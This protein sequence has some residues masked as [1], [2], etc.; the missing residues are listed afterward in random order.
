M[1]KTIRNEYGEEDHPKLTKAIDKAQQDVSCTLELIVFFF[2]KLKIV[3]YKYVY[4]KDR[5]CEE[6]ES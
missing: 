6:T 3:C 1:D 5:V 2:F 4:S